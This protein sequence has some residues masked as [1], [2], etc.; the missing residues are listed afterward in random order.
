MK[1]RTKKRICTVLGFLA[2][3]AML[4]VVRGMDMGIMSVW[5]GAALAAF[6]ELTGAMLLYKSGVFW[7]GR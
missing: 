1:I 5:R 6:C 7:Y 3:L 4:G 2:L